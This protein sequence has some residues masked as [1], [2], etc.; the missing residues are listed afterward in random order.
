M[1]EGLESQVKLLP[2]PRPSLIELSDDR[3]IRNPHLKEGEAN[4]AGIEK[5]LAKTP[6]E[7]LSWNECW[8]QFVRQCERRGYTPAMIAAL[9]WG[10][11][12]ANESS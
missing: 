6:D 1:D 10:D 4:H 12:P 3:F 9:V 2:D 5:M 11:A 8:R 7:R